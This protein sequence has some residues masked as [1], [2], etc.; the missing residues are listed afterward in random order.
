MSRNKILG[1]IFGFCIGDALG[2]PVEFKSREELIKE[3]VTDMLGYGTYD[4]PP[5]TWSDD[6]SLTLC[7]VESLCNGF[8]LEDIAEKYT[9]WYYDA[10]WTPHNVTFGVGNTTKEA[11]CR[12][13]RGVNPEQAGLDDE[14]SNGN[15]SLMRVLPLAFYLKDVEDEEKYDVIHKVSSITH[16]HLRSILACSIY[17]EYAINLLKGYLKDEAYENMKVNI[18]NFYSNT[19]FKKEFDS[20]SRILKYDIA[21]LKEEEIKSS[22]YV[23]DTLEA[24]FWCF[25]NGN[26]YKEVVL[27]AVNLGNDTDTIAA[28]AGGLAGI[29]Y[30]IEAIPKKWIDLVARKDDIIRLTEQFSNRIR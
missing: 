6:T 25:L 24:A 10:Y 27:K 29:Y 18:T 7:L 1:A 5:G 23:V 21:K 13:S 26:G 16:R 12:I 14:Y 9:K 4:Q 19:D 3:P 28:V 30:G 17:V 20:Y 11:I 8:S 2:V 15:G 22:G